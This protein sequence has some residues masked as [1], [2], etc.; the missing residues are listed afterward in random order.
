MEY[1]EKLTSHLR[2]NQLEMLSV[3]TV[4]VAVLRASSAT[5][6]L[7]DYALCG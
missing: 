1:G 5:T 4:E 6:Y 7:C 3:L 2:V